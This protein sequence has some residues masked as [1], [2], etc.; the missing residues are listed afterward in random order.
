MSV[1]I[2]GQVE[3]VVETPGKFGP[4]FGVYVSGTRYGSG[5]TSQGAM[6]GDWVEF[7]ASQNAKGYW[8]IDKGTLKP[9]AAPAG[10]TAFAPSVSKAPNVVS[11]T[12]WKDD[13]QDSIIH[14]SSRKDA[15]HFLQILMDGNLIDFG[16]AKNADKI[17]IMEAF[18]DKYTDHFIEEVKAN[19]TSRASEEKPKDGASAD[20]DG[21]PFDD[22]LPF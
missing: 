2:K 11:G 1:Q 16:K 5:K 20:K 8:D 7:S 14:Q 19:K 12:T 4:M 15:L 3:R 13:R 22:E 6:P 10:A 17:D 21:A 18:L 9:S